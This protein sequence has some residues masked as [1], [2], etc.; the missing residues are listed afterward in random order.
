M[1][2][3]VAAVDDYLTAMAKHDYELLATAVSED[4]VRTGPYGDTYSGRSDYV[5]FIAELLPTLPGHTLDVARVTYADD[6]KRA[7]AEI[8]E[9]VLVNGDPLVTNE[10]LALDLDDGG[11]IKRIDI[12]IKVKPR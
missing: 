8:S 3:P 7:F 4:V 9:T 11:L 12:F 1:A 10:V 6:G 2:G 5:T